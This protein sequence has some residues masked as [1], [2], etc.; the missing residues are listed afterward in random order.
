MKKNSIKYKIVRYNLMIIVVL[1]IVIAIAFSIAFHFYIERETISQLEMITDR[2]I[3]LADHQRPFIDQ[4]LKPPKKALPPPNNYAENVDRDEVELHIMLNRSLK[5]P[6]SV[7]NA[8][9]ILL[10][11]EKNIVTLYPDEFKENAGLSRQ[12]VESISDQSEQFRKEGYL[13]LKIEGTNYIAIAQS[14]SKGNE[15]DS[16]YIIIYASLQNMS[17]LQ[18][19]INCILF[20]ILV[21][22]LIVIVLLSSRLSKKLTEPFI[23][24]NESMKAMEKRDFGKQ[25]EMPVYA[26]LSEMVHSF[27]AMSEKL[28]YYDKAQKTFLQNASHELRTPLM[29]IQSYA[30][31]I[32]FDVVDGDTAAEVIIDESKRM[33]DLVEELLYLS[34]LE[35][36]E[37]SYEFKTVNLAE[38]IGSSINRIK[39]IADKGEIKIHGDIHEDLEISADEQKFSQAMVNILSNCIRYAKTM[40]SVEAERGD[41]G[42]LE[43]RIWDDGPGFSENELPNVFDRFYK[44]EKGNF[45]L[46]L[47]ISKSIIEKHNG[48]ISAQNRASGGALFI[49]KL[50]P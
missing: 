35:S 24:L 15:L 40:V 25:I 36:I 43:V 14:L 37:E 22:S 13:R 34:R 17:H 1:M 41:G 10:D 12:I 18:L 42:L 7:L 31:G 19:M 47:A 4:R 30:E 9:Y 2:A 39:V 23:Y 29:S 32:K 50:E 48:T 49:I 45:G 20:I 21:L 16:G 27:N 26:E 3:E 11:S 5:T 38:L 33:A 46:G 6:L 44:G 8:E 28:A